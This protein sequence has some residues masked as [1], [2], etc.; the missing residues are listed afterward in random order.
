MFALWGDEN[1]MNKTVNQTLSITGITLLSLFSSQVYGIQPGEGIIKDPATG[2]YTIT[3]CGTDSTAAPCVL[4]QVIFVPS[5]KINPSLRASFRWDNDWNIQYRYTLI[6]ESHS[7]QPLISLVLDPVTDI[8][9]PIPL[10]KKWGVRTE[11]QMEAEVNAGRKALQ[12]GTGWE[13]DAL[14]S[15]KGGLRIVWDHRSSSNL[16]AG[17]KPGSSQEGFGLSSK[18]LPGIIA[19][20]F[21]GNSGLDFGFIDSG[22]D[23]EIA[24][25]VHKLQAND[26]VFRYAATPAIA[27]PSP[28][29]SGE[30]LKR[31]QDHAKTWIDMKLLDPVF[32]SR[33]TPL[34]QSAI[35]AANRG[36]SKGLHALITD[37]RDLL[38]KEHPNVDSESDHDSGKGNNRAHIDKLAARVLDFDLKYVLKRSGNP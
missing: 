20:K 7:V 13:G 22:P 23:G 15:D 12:T 17:L 14:P 32:Y 16:V 27:L 36:N 30:L 8:N 21:S 26:F 19:A 29:N 35:D 24:E 37:I 6:N 5:T 38:K 10:S 25:Q 11:K 18:D 31:I 2:N 9:S 28:H 34:F 3:Y 33:L 4:R 1:K